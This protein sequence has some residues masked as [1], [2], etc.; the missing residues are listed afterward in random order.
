MGALGLKEIERAWRESA[1]FAV[2]GFPAGGLC[3]VGGLE[4]H[5]LFETSGSTGVP[6]WIALSKPA[7]ECSARAVN[8]HLRVDE[9]AVWGLSL[10]LL[11]VGGFGVWL[12]ARLAGGRLAVFEGVKGKWSA[13]AYAGWG[14]R[15][16]VTHAALVPTQVTDLVR[17]GLRG[18]AGLRAVVV[19]G[20]RLD[21]AMGQAARDLGWPVLASFGMTEACSQV[22]T[23]GLE[24]LEQPYETNPLRVLPHWRV[25]ATGEGLL[26]LAGPALFSGLL[27]EVAGGVWEYRRREA[28]WYRT[29]DRVELGADGLRP[30]GRADGWV[31]VLGE[32]VDPEG[33]GRDLLEVARRHGE[34]VLADGDFAVVAL[35]EERAGHCLVVVVDAARVAVGRMEEVVLRYHES[36][37]GFRRISAVHRLDGFPRSPLGKVMRADLAAA[38]GRILADGGGGGFSV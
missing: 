3:G 5:V 31:K 34:G 23:Q 14:G 9:A 28:E 7:L 35:P 15:E 10:P 30:L 24:C 1:P 27:V 20:G 22:A 11:H 12:R 2:G 8:E 36:A 17:A 33:V 13:A 26:E 25:R 37:P 32:M 16:R 6:K 19:G 4:D 29:R 18:W 21:R 38:L